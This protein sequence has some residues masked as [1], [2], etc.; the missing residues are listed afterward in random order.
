MPTHYKKELVQNIQDDLP[1]TPEI[2]D[3]ERLKTQ[4]ETDIIIKRQEDGERITA[5]DISNKREYDLYIK[6]SVEN[7][8]EEVAEDGKIGYEDLHQYVDSDRIV[9]INANARK[10]L[11]YGET[12][13]ATINEDRNN[14]R[15]MGLAYHIFKHDLIEQIREIDGLEVGN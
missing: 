9:F 15:M 13:Q 14:T 12:T 10:V 6:Q 7:L 2:K 4:L 8:K 3:L 1:N 5:D 11:H